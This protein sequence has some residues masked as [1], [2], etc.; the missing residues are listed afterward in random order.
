MEKALNK[1]PSALLRWSVLFIVSIAMFGN[2]Y[3]YD[4]IAPIA[5]ILK[6]D[7]GFTDENIGSMYSIYSIAAVIVLIVGGIIIDKFGTKISIL[8][9]SAI[10]TVAAIITAVSPDLDVM[11]AG[12]FIL[13]I[14]AE[15]M[16]VAITTALAK[17][18]K[19]KE[20]GLAL[21]LNLT[22]SRFGQ[23]G[24]DW[25][26]TWASGYYMDW[27]GPLYLA[28][29]IGIICVISG[30]VYYMLEGYANKRYVLGSA[31]ETEKIVWKDLL[32]FNK[33]F[34]FVVILCVTFYSAVFPFRSFAIKFFQEAHDVTREV[35]G[36][37][38]SA[39]P[40]ASMIA[41]PFF[42][43]LADKYGKRALMMMVGSILILPVYLMFVYSG[44]S[45]YVPIMM[46]GISFSLIPAVMWPSIAYLVEEKRLGTAY[47]IMTLIQ[48]VG[49][50]LFN[51]MIG[52]ANDYS[53]A[54][55]ANPQ[56]Y[57]LGMWLFSVLGIIGFIF[58]YLLRKEETGPNNHGLE[59]GMM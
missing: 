23:I 30:I 17:W 56:G 43:F 36:R 2:Y 41:T 12:R 39:L 1:E 46:M 15:P 19:G 42:G 10:C 22:I 25:S 7:L 3:I 50:A 48:Q 13:G 11:L 52:V 6:S 34:W 37:F 45:V 26:P 31:D 55:A 51:Y 18:F 5:D 54:S 27:Q 44:I 29:M 24:A 53:N 9:F 40:I 14:G 59:K 49:V 16:I 20:L 21:G 38:N 57:E 35:A 32:K 47:S 8:L 4:S 58:A 33:S 28:A